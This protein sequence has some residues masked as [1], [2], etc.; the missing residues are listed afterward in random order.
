MDQ[1]TQYGQTDSEFHLYFDEGFH[2]ELPRRCTRVKRLSF[3]ATSKIAALLVR[4]DPPCSG[5]LYGVKD[6][7]ID[8][9]VLSALFAGQSFF[10]IE[11]WPMQVH[12]YLPLMETPELRDHIDVAETKNIALGEIR[13]VSDVRS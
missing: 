3:G 5:E 10:P 7:E 6:R 2:Q 13:E 9:L 1:L 4:I 12:I 8:S 11:K